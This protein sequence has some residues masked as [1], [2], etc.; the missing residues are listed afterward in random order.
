MTFWY[1]NKIQCVCDNVTVN[2]VCTAMCM[3]RFPVLGGFTI[4]LFDQ[5]PSQLRMPS[6]YCKRVLGDSH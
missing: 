3:Y 1:E 6:D 2:S 4:L 5:V